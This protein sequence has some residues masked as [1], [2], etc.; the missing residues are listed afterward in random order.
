M[1]KAPDSGSEIGAVPSRVDDAS[2]AA[3][4]LGEGDLREALIKHFRDDQHIQEQVTNLRSYA[5]GMRNYA[6]GIIACLGVILSVVVFAGPYFLKLG[7]RDAVAPDIESLKSEMR[8]HREFIRI[9]LG[10]LDTAVSAAAA[11]IEA[12]G[13][14]APPFAAPRRRHAATATSQDQ[15]P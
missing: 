4:A 3:I 10:K 6:R 2:S 7:I 9:S 13:T 1:R 14:P 15:I 11:A 8:D 5:K 12:P